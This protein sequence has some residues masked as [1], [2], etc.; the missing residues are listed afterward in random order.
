MLKEWQE[1]RGTQNRPEGCDV[2]S[3][4]FFPQNVNGYFFVD[5]DF[6]EAI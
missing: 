6:L 1:K 5:T 2:K 4:I 3:W